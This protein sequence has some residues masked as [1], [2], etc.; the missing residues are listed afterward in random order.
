MIMDLEIDESKVFY[1]VGS[2]LGVISILYFGHELILDLSPTV[3]SLMLF[4]GTA[5][6]LGS[7][8]IF[9]NGLLKSS[10]YIFSA[11]SYLSF[12]IYLFAKFSLSSTQVFGVLSASSVLFIG[13]G[14]LR[15]E[16][17][18]SLDKNQSKKVLAGILIVLSVLIAFDLTG[19]QAEYNLSLNEQVEVTEGEEFELGVLEITNEFPLSRDID[20]PNFEGC[21]SASADREPSQIFISPDRENIISGSSKIE[22]PLTDEV[23]SRSGNTSISGNYGIKQGECPGELENQTI[24][25]QET[26]GNSILRSVSRD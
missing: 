4:S 7:A 22:I 1:S 19:A 11:F 8:D 2:F 21:I 12:L 17:E 13:L 5:L 18:Y 24:Y 15:S 23:H 26:G 6:F 16:K 9:E 10:F 14:Y 20:I 25:V 3:K